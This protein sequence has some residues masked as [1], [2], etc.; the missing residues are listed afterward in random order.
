MLV[1]V[2]DDYMK[3]SVT[4]FRTHSILTQP[5]LGPNSC[6][7]VKRSRTIF[8]MQHC[9]HEA[10]TEACISV[11]TQKK[12]QVPVKIVAHFPST[13]TCSDQ[14]WTLQPDKNVHCNFT[15]PFCQE[16]DTY[17]IQNCRKIHGLQDFK[18]YLSPG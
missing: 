14:G 16:Y 18:P 6:T 4:Q 17:M 11:G 2:K 7:S 3:T 5:T 13:M 9:T 15:T 1:Q 10:G 8:L 12:Q